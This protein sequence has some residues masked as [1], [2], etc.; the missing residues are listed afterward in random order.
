M[1]LRLNDVHETA[2]RHILLVFFR[3]TTQIDREESELIFKCNR[4][5]LFIIRQL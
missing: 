4:L 5:Q 1:P 3:S 2:V